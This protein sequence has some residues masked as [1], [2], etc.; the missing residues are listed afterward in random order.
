MGRPREPLNCMVAYDRHRVIG[1]AGTLPWHHPEDLRHFKRT[2]MGHAI[3]HGR[4][5]YEDFGKPLP[6]RQTLVITRGKQPHPD[7]AVLDSPARLLDFETDREVFICGG[8]TIYRETM[9]WVSELFLT[10]VQFF[11]AVV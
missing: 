10:V 7:V 2:T 1:R 3:I 5:S 6:R 11:E 4:T 8:E 9:P